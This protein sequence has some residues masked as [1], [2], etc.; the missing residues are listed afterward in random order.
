MSTVLRL[1]GIHAREDG[2]QLCQQG[3]MLNAP[4]RND[5][6]LSTRM[7]DDVDAA[8]GSGHSDGANSP[9]VVYRRLA[10]DCTVRHA[11]EVASR[12]GLKRYPR[13]WR[14]RCPCC[15]YAT[16]TFSVLEGREGRARLYCANGCDQYE[17]AR[18]VA[19]STGH[20]PAPRPANGP[21]DAATRQRNR[22]RALALWNGAVPAS[23]TLADHYLTGRGLP[24]L[25][26][27]PALRFR[28]DTPHPEGARLPA[29]LALVQDAA[30]KPLGVHRTYLATDGRK[31]RV[32][33]AKASLGPIWSGAIRLQPL[34]TGGP[35]VIGEGIETAASAGRMMGLP[36]WAG[37]SAG[38]I[39]GGLQLPA[40]AR[41]LV[42][43]ADPDQA[44]ESSAHTAALRWSAEG[45]RVQIARP[46]GS[47]D[48]NDLLRS[49]ASDG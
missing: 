12:L 41:H 9:A 29:L 42:I 28:R 34:P 48:F 19:R 22:E 4:S 49:E 26:A 23:G 43:A 7:H 1:A 6:I 44:G 13:S 47:G 32:E 36:A 25:A 15:Q 18:A 27:S 17:L 31:A 40:E 5:A 10:R 33:P 16:P 21:T 39:A 2:L 20:A 11:V 45:R 37:I 35:L 14:G 24:E 8:E 38:N 30:G 46:T 3:V